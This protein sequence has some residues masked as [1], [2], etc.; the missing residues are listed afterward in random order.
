[1]QAIEI[2][3]I[4]KVN[5]NE[6]QAVDDSVAVEKKIKIYVNDEEIVTLA[7]SPF[8]IKE[9]VVGFLMT[10]GILKGDWCPE[11]MN[12]K[13]NERQIEVQITLE[14]FVCTEGKTITSGCISSL[15]F[16][17]D[18]KG[19]VESN[20]KIEADCLLRLFKSF[21]QN[22]V[23]Y[24]T[25]GCI[26]AAAIADINELLFIGEDIGRH[27][28]VDKVIGWCLLNKISFRDKII[29]ISGRVSSEM[30]LKVAKWKIPFVVSR[31]A[32][33]SLAVDFAEK[34]G[35]TLIGFLRGQR[36]NIYSHSER[37]EF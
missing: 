37:L 31:T 23:L 6:F 3:K 17:S 1:M 8:Q 16:L 25:T 2:R 32:P 22:S 36:F 5:Q 27:N 30:I 9:L 19:C 14:G 21:Q 29:L 10:E 13:E 20:M 33:T 24:K 35:I 4:F 11:K 15:S 26:H 34:A 7:A 28:A 18:V 12:V